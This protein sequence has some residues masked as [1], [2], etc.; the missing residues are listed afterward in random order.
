[1]TYRQVTKK[2]KK[3]GCT[4]IRRRGGGSHRLWRNPANGRFTTVPDWGS[5]DLKTGTVRGVVR[6]LGLEWADFLGA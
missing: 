6:Q 5:K 1:M 4:E 2:L 3:L